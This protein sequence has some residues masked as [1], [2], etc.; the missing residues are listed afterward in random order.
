MSYKMFKTIRK[1]N[2]VYDKVIAPNKNN[3]AAVGTKMDSHYQ[4]MF[5][6]KNFKRSWKIW[7]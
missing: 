6:V 5:F 7:I 2:L 1:S 4:A 3:K